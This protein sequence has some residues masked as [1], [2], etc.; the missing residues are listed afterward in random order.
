MAICALFFKPNLVFDLPREPPF[1][2][3]ATRA[4]FSDFR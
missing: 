1:F 2:N 3:A 4:A